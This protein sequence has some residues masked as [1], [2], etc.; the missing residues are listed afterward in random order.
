MAVGDGREGTEGAADDTWDEATD[1]VGD[2]E[3]DG[4]DGLGEGV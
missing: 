3:E 1:V 4:E 2:E